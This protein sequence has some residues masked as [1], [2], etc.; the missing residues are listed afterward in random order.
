MKHLVTELLMASCKMHFKQCY[1]SEDSNVLGCDPVLSKE[2]LT[3]QKFYNA[4]IFRGR[5]PRE[6][7]LGLLDPEGESTTVL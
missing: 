7:S 5:T 3:F 2:L 4:Y 6:D 1:Y